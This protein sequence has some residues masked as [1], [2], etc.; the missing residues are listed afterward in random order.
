MVAIIAT[1]T[2]FLVVPILHRIDQ[3]RD[4]FILPFLDIPPMLS[5]LLLER[6]E[7]H[8]HAMHSELASP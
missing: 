4:H 6:C 5:S 7:S 1:L 8:L 3:A 2:L